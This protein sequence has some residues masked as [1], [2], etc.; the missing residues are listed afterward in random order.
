[1]G[2]VAAIMARVII[3]ILGKIFVILLAS[4]KFEE[5]GTI[6]FNAS[7]SCN[8]FSFGLLLN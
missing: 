2:M 5:L 4:I 1:M 3:L 6:L 7:Y 8:T